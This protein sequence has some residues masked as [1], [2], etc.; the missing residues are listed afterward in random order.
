M[1]AYI[2]VHLLQAL[3]QNYL[4]LRADGPHHIPTQVLPSSSKTM[5]EPWVDIP[6]YADRGK[7]VLKTI[8]SPE[9]EEVV[10][11]TASRWTL[12][13]SG[14]VVHSKRVDG[15]F[16]LVY[17]HK[18][19][20]GG[21]AKHVNGD[22]LDNR[23]TNLIPAKPRVRKR[24]FEMTTDDFHVAR[25][26]DSTLDPASLSDAV[27]KA[28]IDYG[29]GKIY[30]GEL[31]HSKPHGLGILYEDGLKRS[32]GKWVNGTLHNGIVVEFEQA[33]AYITYRNIVR[34]FLVIGGTKT[35][36]VSTF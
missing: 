24:P 23:R 25:C 28:T 32:Y 6:V 26:L 8:I 12:S 3:I 31:L 19:I 21:S 33:P 29:K 11:T 34:C 22:R 35:F 2:Y 5:P 7:V 13:G 16:T 15:K 36:D 4:E 9:D 18:V 30:S 10:R 17:L 1:F 27:K 20:M 14:Y